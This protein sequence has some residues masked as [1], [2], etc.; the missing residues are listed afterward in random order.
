MMQP[1]WNWTRP[2]DLP[3]PSLCAHCIG[4]LHVMMLSGYSTA[5]AC[6]CARCGRPVDLALC[7]VSRC[8]KCGTPEGLQ[9]VKFC[10]PSGPWMTDYICP[11][12]TFK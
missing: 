1:G 5:E 4:G 9:E 10:P 8:A 3:Y 6:T 12:C 2:D 7:K 11:D